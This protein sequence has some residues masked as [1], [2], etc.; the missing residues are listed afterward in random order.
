MESTEAG[1]FGAI[2]ITPADEKPPDVESTIYFHHFNPGITMAARGSRLRRT[3]SAINGHAFAGNTP[4]VMARSG[5]DVQFNVLTLGSEFHTFHIHGHRWP[6]PDKHSVDAP[7]LGPS[8]GLKA[9]F[10]EDAPGRWLYHC[11]VIEH[12][13]H[14]MVGYYVVSE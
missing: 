8:E 9:R 3:V 2:V 4:T 13:H 10:K 11:H 14:G 7:A 1:L 12:M 6:A 5:Q